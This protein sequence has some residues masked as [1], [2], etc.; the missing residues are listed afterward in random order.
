[1]EKIYAAPING[2]CYA[3][4]V[5][6]KKLT[7]PLSESDAKKIVD[8]YNGFEELETENLQLVGG[9]TVLQIENSS[10]AKEIKRLK[11]QVEVLSAAF[12]NSS[13]KEKGL[14]TALDGLKGLLGTEQDATTQYFKVKVLEAEKD[15]LLDFLE[16]VAFP[17]E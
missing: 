13:E 11:L 1:M 4:F 17:P 8:R 10:A 16:N 15:E 2:E 9:I 6:D 7:L 5:G 3:V 12:A 14:R